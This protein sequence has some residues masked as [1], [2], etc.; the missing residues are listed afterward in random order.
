MSN[1]DKINP[2]HL[3][4]RYFHGPANVLTLNVA[5]RHRTHVSNISESEAEIYIFVPAQYFQNLCEKYLP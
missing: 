3:P 1:K 4:F 2:F 5:L